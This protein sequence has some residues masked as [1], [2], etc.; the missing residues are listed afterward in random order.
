MA[1]PVSIA[2]GIAGLATLAKSILTSV[3]TYWRAVRS[4]PAEFDNI[5]RELIS[6]SSVLA[7]LEPM[8]E[9]GWAKRLKWTLKEEDTKGLLERLSRHKATLQLAIS[10][11]LSMHLVQITNQ[12]RSHAQFQEEEK[13]SAQ[14]QRTLSWLSATNPEARNLEIWQRALPNT[15][16]WFINSRKYMAWLEGSGSVLLCMGMP[17]AGKTVLTSIIV[18]DLRTRFASNPKVGIAFLYCDYLDRSNQTAEKFL[19]TLVKQLAGQNHNVIDK[20]Q[21][22]HD[23]L[24]VP[25]FSQWRQLFLSLN[26]DFEQIY[27]VIDAFD[28]CHEQE[29]RSTLLRFLRDLSCAS[30]KCFN[31]LVTSRPYSRDL[32]AT[33]ETA[34]RIEVKAQ[35]DDI[36]ALVL[37]AIRKAQASG[38]SINHD[39]AS[40][41]AATLCAK[42]EGMFL[43]VA[44][45]LRY[46]LGQP[47][48]KLRRSALKQVPK[49][50]NQTY[51]LAIDTIRRLETGAR[52]L[53]F[54]ALMW[55]NRAT[56]PLTFDE[57]ATALAVEDGASQLDIDA[58][59]EREALI[60]ICLGLVVCDAETGV[61]R[62]M[63][64]TVKEFFDSATIPELDRD[65]ECIARTCLTYLM[66]DQFRHE[67]REQPS[68]GSW[69]FQF[70]PS[71]TP[72]ATTSLLP[73]AARHW[74]QHLR[75]AKEP[76]NLVRMAINFLTERR[77]LACASL[78]LLSGAWAKPFYR[79]GS[80]TPL[81]YASALG[82]PEVVETL[83]VDA[84]S[85]TYVNSTDV[86]RR[87]ITPNYRHSIKTL[88]YPHYALAAVEG[89][90]S[91][92][93]AIFRHQRSCRAQ[94][95]PS[96]QLDHDAVMTMLCHAIHYHQPS[97]VRLLLREQ[98]D[99]NLN[100]C[101]KAHWLP[102]SV[103]AVDFAPQTL[104]GAAVTRGTPDMV[105][106]LIQHPG[107]DVNLKDPEKEQTAL[108][109]GATKGSPEVVKVLLSRG[110]LDV[111]CRDFFGRT[112]LILATQNRHESIVALL[113]RH[114]EV[115]VN[116]VDGGHFLSA[117]AWASKEGYQGIVGLLLEREDLD[118]FS[119]FKGARV[120]CAWLRRVDM[121]QYFCYY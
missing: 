82:L 53:A 62:F 78:E 92:I 81:Q 28:E 96:I 98:P 4:A 31:I 115:N 3:Y 108:A 11:D 32:N 79:Y 56:R 25:G 30:S 50:L 102:P 46:I 101:V 76:A 52:E 43:L 14:N 94:Q 33:F 2:S 61:M 21:P 44:L 68:I 111:N 12:L 39:F 88:S 119:I 83:L 26:Q 48:L 18:E 38:T 19:R 35:H 60:H 24:S 97:I 13:L 105:Q 34:T 16:Q 9:A 114:R 104:L 15:C 59:I 29:Q 70:S 86:K 72:S 67:A 95:V 89:H 99:L 113:L 64:Y 103:E 87:R 57:L 40:E 77:D 100:V 6:L 5:M 37:E 84:E 75:L 36:K 8:A 7:Q 58:I 55:I 120:P 22:L 47:T 49:E 73:Y 23:T 69:N 51:D 10:A 54:Q 117:L 65:H 93:V 91:V 85:S 106:I 121:M 80:L 110:D 118:I 17:G 66:F 71:T 45:Q 63:H 41:V 109:L 1:D 116:C 20:V 107:L 90:E 112:P 74:F 27:I 42:A